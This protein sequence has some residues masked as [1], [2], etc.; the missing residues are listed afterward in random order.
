MRH[1]RSQT[2]QRR[3]HHALKEANFSTCTNCQALHRPHHMCLSCGFYKGRQ[4]MDLAAEKAKRDARLKAKRERIEGDVGVPG[5]VS[6]Q[7]PAGA[8]QPVVDEKKPA[9]AEARAAKAKA[10][11]VK[12]Q[13]FAPPRTD[14][15][16]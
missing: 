12:R 3:S 9:R 16:Q 7:A 15:G 2:R 5:E 13:D 11:A 10:S 8:P 14:G 1:N 6:A 4:V